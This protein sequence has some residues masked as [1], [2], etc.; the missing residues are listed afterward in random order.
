VAK[1]LHRA[2][3]KS[4][5]DRF[6]TVAEF[7]KALAGA[8]LPLLARIPAGRARTAVYAT[9]AI[10]ALALA[11]VA[12]AL[13]WPER[14]SVPERDPGLVAVAPFRNDT[15]DPSFDIFGPLAA[16]NIQH[17]LEQSGVAQ[18][19]SPSVVEPFLLSAGS[20]PDTVSFL[21]DGL[22]AGIVVTGRLILLGDSLQI[23]ASCFDAIRGDDFFPVQPVTVPR[24]SP[25]ETLQRIPDRVAAV[26]A[27]FLDPG[28]PYEA[29]ES[30]PRVLEAYR[31]FRRA[32][33][34][35]AQGG[36]DEAMINHYL[37]ASELDSAYVIPLL[38]VVD[39]LRVTGR[40][41]EM[42]SVLGV[43][44]SRRRLM[45]PLQLLLFD[46]LRLG[47]EGDL[48]LALLKAREIARTHPTEIAYLQGLEAL[49]LNLLDE[50][51]G[52]LEK[53]EKKEGGY[54]DAFVQN[55]PLYFNVYAI[56]LH[57]LDRHRKALE[58]ALEGQRRFPAIGQYR[59]REMEALAA[60]GDMEGLEPLV[61]RDRS[62]EGYALFRI[63]TTTDELRAHG[64]SE[65]ARAI[66]EEEV[67]RF[68]TYPLYSDTVR[69]ARRPHN[70]AHVLH[71]LGREEE[72]H[73]LWE[74]V[75][76]HVPRGHEA[77][78]LLG[79]TAAL[80]G[81]TAQARAM[82]QRLAD[83]PDSE[84]D[85]QRPLYRAWIAAAL[86]EKERAVELL[87]ELPHLNGFRMLYLH[88]DLNLEPLKGYPAFEAFM[89]SK[90]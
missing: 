36:S 64:Y 9:V 11:A 66:L 81:D 38:D 15:G 82:D 6:R 67:G 85:R 77:V 51:S 12:G 25:E 73:L 57:L 80:I 78:G 45:T 14:D 42:D 19:V 43:L 26:I 76:P 27:Q 70:R 49:S 17:H 69:P 28:N 88:R 48:E 40:Y 50:A 3:A 60:M 56:V 65:E 79:A 75:V 8:T 23:R 20:V 34:V 59:D 46:Y 41:E 39:L 62:G 18:A 7:E 58:V 4:P 32:P 63:W 71:R 90:G 83:A 33:D 21:S 30:P 61:D 31:E 10:L 13:L 55:Q 74:E 1:A 29:F 84:S 54:L 5:A 86:G 72:A 89:E 24:D 52:A 68:D 16:E 2:L 37:R 53:W 35:R 47:I 87:R 22:G 44:E